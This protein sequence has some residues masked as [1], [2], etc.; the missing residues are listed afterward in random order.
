MQLLALLLL[1]GTKLLM[2]HLQKGHMAVPRGQ[3]SIM[4]SAHSAATQHQDR[5]GSS[6]H[7][8]QHKLE[9]AHV[10]DTMGAGM[11]AHTGTDSMCTHKIQT[12]CASNTQHGDCRT[13][14]S[15]HSATPPACITVQRFIVL[16]SQHVGQSPVCT[17]SN[18]CVHPAPELHSP[19]MVC[20]QGLTTALGTASKHT[21]QVWP[22]SLLILPQHCCCCVS[23]Q[24]VTTVPD[25]A[26]YSSNRLSSIPSVPRQGGK[27]HTGQI[28]VSTSRQRPQCVCSHS[29]VCMLAQQIEGDLVSS[30]ADGL[31]QLHHATGP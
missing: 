22:S 27:R 4:S 31:Q 12:A 6:R 21:P 18:C 17:N 15:L 20:L 7:D 28:Q 24:G 2:M 11:S 26:M 10:V 25:S 14:R 19:H 16:A 29:L 1:T 30:Q 5:H 9:Q 23:V 3:R 8:G 13:Q